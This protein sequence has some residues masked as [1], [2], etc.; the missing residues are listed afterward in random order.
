MGFN[1]C[2][3]FHSLC[4][5]AKRTAHSRDFPVGNCLVYIVLFKNEFYN[6]TENIMG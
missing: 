3:S 5:G 2:C 6:K 4:H 1:F